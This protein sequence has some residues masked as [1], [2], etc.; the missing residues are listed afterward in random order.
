VWNLATKKAEVRT[1]PGETYQKGASYKLR[2][3]FL[4]SD[5]DTV[6]TGDLTVKPAQSKVKHPI[7]KSTLQHQSRAGVENHVKI[8]LKA[9]SP[10]GA[11]IE[12]FSIKKNPNDAYWYYFDYKEQ[13]L[14]IWIRDGALAKPGKATLVFSAVYEGQGLENTGTKAKP[15]YG[16]KPVDLK[17]PVTV[18]R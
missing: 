6:Y 2:L 16:L 12:N 7:P 15:K 8:D 3:E 4:T 9:T 14:H 10:A 11:K 18:A 1:K 13:A 17:I 5:G